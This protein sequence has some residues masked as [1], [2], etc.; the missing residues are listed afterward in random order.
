MS[1]DNTSFD[2]NNEN[3]KAEHFRVEKNLIIRNLIA[4]DSK[5]LIDN[6]SLTYTKKRG[7]TLSLVPRVEALAS[8]NLSKR[9]T[10]KAPRQ[11]YLILK[12]SMVLE[13]FPTPKRAV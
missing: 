1:F 11:M 2:N 13:K 12:P 10:L 4:Y 3:K 9:A 6:S 5:R 7:A 8:P